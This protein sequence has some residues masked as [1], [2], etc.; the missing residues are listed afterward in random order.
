MLKV[1]EIMVK[2]CPVRN[3]VE[4]PEMQEPERQKF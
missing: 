3:R 4:N 1:T 2:R